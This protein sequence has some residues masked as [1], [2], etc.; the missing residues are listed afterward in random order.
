MLPFGDTD[1]D[2]G[3]IDND[4]TDDDDDDNNDNGD[5]DDDDDSKEDYIDNYGDKDNSRRSLESDGL[6]VLRKK[7]AD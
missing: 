7:R 3:D 6:L 5:I 1:N 2:N 4:N